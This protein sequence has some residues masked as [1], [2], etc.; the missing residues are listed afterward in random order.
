MARRD[1]TVHRRRFL[2]ISLLGL[3]VIRPLGAEAQKPARI[4]LLVSGPPPE[5]HVCV[6]A[7][8]R[9]LAGLAYVEGL[10]YVFETRSTQGRPEEAFPR[11]GAELVKRGVD[12]IVSVA[13][14]GLVEAK[15]AMEPSPSS[16][17]QA[18]TPSSADS[19][20]AWD[21]REAI[22]PE[23]RRSLVRSLPSASNS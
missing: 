11:F 16:W 18:P 5:D 4:G 19:W 7:L 9:G 2:L 21:G 13:G 12:L 1:V 6:Q 15:G 8:R 17:R 3:V 10:T 14:Q 20:A 23:W 22:S